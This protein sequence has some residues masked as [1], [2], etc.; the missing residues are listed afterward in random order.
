MQ[1]ELKNIK[2]P[3]FGLPSFEPRITESIY[4]RRV[5]NLKQIMHQRDLD[6]ILVYGDREH[7]ANLIY[8]SGYDPRFEEGIL[9]VTKR[10]DPSSFGRK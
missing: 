10:K 8:L 9:I 5:E 2:L 3:E 6:M 1:I 4:Y 7:N